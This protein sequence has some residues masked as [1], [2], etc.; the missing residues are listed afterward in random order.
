MRTYSFYLYD[1]MGDLLG[2][3]SLA[4][5]SDDAG[6]TQAREILFAYPDC[7]EVEIWEALRYVGQGRRTGGDLFGPAQ[8][9]D[10]HSDL[11][12]RARVRH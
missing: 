3:S 10:F 11:G 7:E 5:E 6:R 9:R 1:D 2:S 12:E 8:R 4:L